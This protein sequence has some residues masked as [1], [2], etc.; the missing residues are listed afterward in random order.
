MA[1]DIEFGLLGVCIG[2]G[3]GRVIG[4]FRL[5]RATG[6]GNID[7]GGGKEV[8]FEASANTILASS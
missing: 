8:S 2:R 1:A 5:E 7:G 3:G 4:P 6:E